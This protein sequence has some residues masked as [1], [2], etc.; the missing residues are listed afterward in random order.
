MKHFSYAERL[1]KL[2]LRTLEERRLNLDLVFTFNCLHGFYGTD[3][4]DIELILSTS[5]TRGHNFKLLYM[6]NNAK[7]RASF[8]SARVV[9]ALNALPLSAVNSTTTDSFKRLLKKVNLTK[10]LVQVL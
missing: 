5:I 2:G 4:E 3:P 9:K 1:E 6:Q 8:L 10:F 7:F